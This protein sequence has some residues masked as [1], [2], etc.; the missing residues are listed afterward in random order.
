MV[1]YPYLAYIKKL[2]TEILIQNGMCVTLLG[3]LVS[4]VD[5]TCA[6]RKTQ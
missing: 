1:L 3:L 6:A 2:V 5:R 4:G